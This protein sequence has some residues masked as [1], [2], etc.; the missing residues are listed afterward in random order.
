MDVYSVADV[1]NAITLT[2]LNLFAGDETSM[3]WLSSAAISFAYL[4]HL[5][6]LSL[7][8]DCVRAPNFNMHTLYL[9]IQFVNFKIH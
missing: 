4:Y 8:V 7:C 6:I 3:R 5:S 9:L 1:L 2:L